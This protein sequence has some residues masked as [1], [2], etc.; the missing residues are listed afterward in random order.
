MLR[1][2]DVID[3]QLAEIETALMEICR[4]QESDDA[5]RVRAEIHIVTADQV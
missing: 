1:G 3:D 4:E 5:V 2:V